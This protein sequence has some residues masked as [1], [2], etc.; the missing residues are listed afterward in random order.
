VAK[1]KPDKPYPE[2]P[3]FAHANGQWAKKIHGKLHYFGSWSDSKAAL[4][5]FQEECDYLYADQ[6]PPEKGMSVHEALHHFLDAKQDLVDSGELSE[7]SLNDYVSTFRRLVEFFGRDRPIASL[8]QTDFGSYR[9]AMSKRIGPT[10]VGNEVRRIKSA[11]NWLNESGLITDYIRVGPDFKQ[12]SAKAVRQSRQGKRDK[13]IEAKDVRKLVAAAQGHVKAMILLGIN[14]GYG[15][16]DIA[17]LELSS[18]DLDSGWLEQPRAKTGVPRRAWLWPETIKALRVALELRPNP[19]PE[20]ET[21]F[22][23][24]MFGRLW[25]RSHGSTWIDSVRLEFGKVAEACKIDRTFYNLRHT[26]RTVTDETGDTN[27]AR[28]VMG[29]TPRAN[30]MDAT[31]VQKIGDERIKSV[32]QHVRLWLYG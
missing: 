15:N 26:H 17:Q 7:R 2:Y 19:K 29:H 21:K 30:D 16:N 31:Y 12:P 13:F 11:I 23:V 24:T 5:K 1:E 32:C 14:A 27:A 18:V 20:A 4:A 3:L 9:A 10:T 8:K 6:R 25:V 22:F 28:L